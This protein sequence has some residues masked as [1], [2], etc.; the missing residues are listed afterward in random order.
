MIMGAPAGSISRH[1]ATQTTILLR[2]LASP[3]RMAVHSLYSSQVSVTWRACRRIAW[4]LTATFVRRPD[5][6]LNERFFAWVSLL[7]VRPN[8]ML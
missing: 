7:P 6:Q 8:L 2:L 5:Q 3:V 4:V 1:V